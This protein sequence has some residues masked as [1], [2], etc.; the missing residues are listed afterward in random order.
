MNKKEYAETIALCTGAQKNKDV[1]NWTTLN[2]FDNT[3]KRNRNT[4]PKD[5]YTKKY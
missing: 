2:E 1:A 3:S 5:R 4:S